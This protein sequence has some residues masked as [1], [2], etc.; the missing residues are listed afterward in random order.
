MFVLPSRQVHL[1]FHTSEHLFGIGADFKK[2]QFQE[3]LKLGHINSIT[4]FAKCH[5]GFCYYPTKVG[6]FHPHLKF[7]LTGSMIEAA[8]E[9]GVKAPVYITTG[10]SA[11]DA[12]EHP[13]WL[14]K[15]ADGSVAY[16]NLDLNAKPTD[17]R[18]IVSWKNLC[19]N[20]DYANHICD[21]TRE[22]CERYDNLDGLFYDICFTGYTCYCNT[23]I[24][25]MEK[26]NLD[27]KNEE[28]AKS[29]YIIKRQE[30]MQN[31]TSILREKH[32]NATI[33][34]NGGAEQHRPEYHSLQSHFELEDLPT[35][36]NRGYDVLIIRAKYFA[37]TGK[38]YL[39]MSGKF[40]T[41]WGE[42]G[43]FKTPVALKYECAAM[44]T[45]GAKCSIGDQLHPCGEMDL[46]TY[47]IIGEAY[48]YVEQIEEY[49]FNTT[50][51]TNLGIV[52]SG[53]PQSDEGLSKMLL[54][55]Q[56]DFD[57]ILEND[58]LS[59]FETV[60]L[61]DCVLL[62]DS[63]A[64]KIEA[65]I[66]NGGGVLLT[67]ESG[68]NFDKSEFLIDIG[69]K[70]LGAS[71]Y[72]IDYV[73]LGEKVNENLVTSPFLFY[74]S[75]NRVLPTNCEILGEIFEPYFNRT[76]EKYSSHQNTPNKRTPAEYPAI[77]QKGKVVYIAHKICEM[78]FE[79]GSQ[80]HRDYLINAL[81]LI[82]KNPIVNVNLMSA[83]RARFVKQ[84]A[85]NRYILH[86][87]YASPIQRGIA[88]VIEDM[89]MIY[90]IPVKLK[91]N[92][93]IKNVYLAMS[94]ERIDFDQ[95]STELYFTVPN[96]QCHQ[97]VILDY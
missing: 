81:K 57:I 67:G 42:F 79:Y 91:V 35:A 62:N 6:T 8:H 51:T 83:G 5:H 50:E 38:Q 63:F 17:E 32:K 85:N 92:Q 20:G 66:H 34:F 61:P 14:A 64:K 89:P 33:F 71:E 49:C 70:Q 29:Y 72:K 4:V 48:K 18:P 7:D 74:T 15:N 77:V 23:C 84:D 76:Y 80:Y 93:P 88:T 41:Y 97:A 55:S 52:L 25:G 26:L 94:K 13:E 2:E 1:D 37:K 75:A 86:L 45:Y 59:K 78:Y 9:I 87:L 58:D 73:Q 12:Q 28:D 31:C 47:R 95:S 65:F 22:V 19:L 54:Q 68:L 69:A 39:G 16:T 11:L 43:G 44:A 56:L 40:H 96:I 3:A 46:E 27:T 82:Y 24:S 36:W 60:I 21:I 53:N 90:N 10:W 30:L